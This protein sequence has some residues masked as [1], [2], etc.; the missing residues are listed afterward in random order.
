PD[1][2][3]QMFAHVS[4]TAAEVGLTLDFDNVIAANTFDAHRL[5]HLAGKRQNELLVALFKAH[6]SDGKVIDDREVLG[7]LA[8]SVGLD[9]DV[10]REQLGSDA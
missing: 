9:A 7:E 10:G 4:A 5:L 1:Q 6:F 2:V 3:R 8:V